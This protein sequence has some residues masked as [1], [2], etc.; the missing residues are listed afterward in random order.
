[1]TVDYTS[2]DALKSELGISDTTDDPILQRCV[3][4]GSRAVDTIARARPGEFGRSLET[5]YY[6]VAKRYQPVGEVDRAVSVWV[7]RY[8][9]IETLKTDGDGD[10]TYDETWVAGQDY[11]EV[12]TEGPPYWQ[13]MV[14]PING[15]Y[16]GFPVG[17][18][19]VELYATFGDY[20]DSTVAIASRAALLMAMR[21]WHRKKSPEGIVGDADRGFTYLREVDPDVAIAVSNL[22]QDR[23]RFA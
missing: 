4:H 15:Q 14:D 9:S 5:R 6:D 3:T 8:T 2:L 18:R 11:W 19:R 13:L 12:P 22:R 10:R 21:F 16:S 7:D 20:D 17:V 23:G 1:M